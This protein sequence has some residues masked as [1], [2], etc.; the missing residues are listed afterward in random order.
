MNQKSG[1]EGKSPDVETQPYHNAPEEPQQRQ[2]E[3]QPTPAKEENKMA[4]EQT[5]N[6]TA[7]T[8][9]SRPESRTVRVKSVPTAATEEDLSKA[10]EEVRMVRSDQRKRFD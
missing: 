6:K 3:N 9:G 8:D 5:E 2:E 1:E 4:L 7:K 10:F